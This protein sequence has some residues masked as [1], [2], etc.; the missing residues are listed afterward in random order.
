M[1][2]TPFHLQSVDSVGASRRDDF[3]PPRETST[4]RLRKKV[5]VQAGRRL[6]RWGALITVVCAG[7]LPLTGVAHETAIPEQDAA[8]YSVQ[9]AA[10]SPEGKQLFA[11][12]LALAGT[13]ILMERLCAWRLRCSRRRLDLPVIA[14]LACLGASGAFAQSSTGPEPAAPTTP[15]PKRQINRESDL[16]RF[17]YPLT[18]PPSALVNADDATF[19]A[20]ADKVAADLRRTL[21]DCDIT[22]K[23]TR[24]NLLEPLL[25]QALLTGQDD[26]ARQLLPQ[27]QANEDKEER[28]LLSWRVDAAY[29]QAAQTAGTRTGPEFDRAFEAADRALVDALAL[30]HSAGG[31]APGAG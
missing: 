19:N 6:K 21:Q 9:N 22:D 26:T 16:P 23:G 15:G 29:L 31:D 28:R 8:V 10:W 24:R 13:L 7:F 20:F 25:C 14:L 1:K 12:T 17:S 11:V 5:T 4:N 18:I 30:G 2:T 27:W 3:Y